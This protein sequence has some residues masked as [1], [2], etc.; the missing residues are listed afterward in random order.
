MLATYF[1][2]CLK[3][4][5]H[6]DCSDTG[7]LSASASGLVVC[8]SLF[9]VPSVD[10]FRLDACANTTRTGK[11]S[12]DDQRW[13]IGRQCQRFERYAI[14]SAG[15]ISELSGPEQR[16]KLSL[17][18]IVR[19]TFVVYTSVLVTIPYLPLLDRSCLSSSF[20]TPWLCLAHTAVGFSL[21]LSIDM[22][23]CVWLLHVDGHVQSWTTVLFY[24]YRRD[25]TDRPLLVDEESHDSYYRLSSDKFLHGY[26]RSEKNPLEH[27]RTGVW[28]YPAHEILFTHRASGSALLVQAIRIPEC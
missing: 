19:M 4:V 8:Q 17:A 1:T 9:C 26:A 23:V 10:T 13:A 28:N 7:Q 15:S 16:N 3:Y 6:S 20:K 12:N 2:S 22:R 11:F 14:A 5:M 27:D 25:I 24:N 21:S 18:I